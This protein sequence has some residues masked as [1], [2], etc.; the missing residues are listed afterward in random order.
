MPYPSLP[1]N[2]RQ[3]IQLAFI[4]ITSVK[5]YEYPQMQ[6]LT[7]S[8]TDPRVSTDVPSDFFR[9]PSRC[10]QP[11]GLGTHLLEKVGSFNGVGILIVLLVP[12]SET[13]GVKLHASHQ[14]CYPFLADF[15]TF[16]LNTL[17]LR[18]DP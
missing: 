9:T 4:E 17:V 13:F 10:F 3:N 14:P 8:A 15:Y 2:A 16:F 18:I 1:L 6:D 12:V 5:I 7:C 11:R